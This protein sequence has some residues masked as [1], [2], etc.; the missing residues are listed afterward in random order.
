MVGL[1]VCGVV[2]LYLP[3]SKDFCRI[4][5]RDLAYRYHIVYSWKVV[6][7]NTHHKSSIGG[8]DRQTEFS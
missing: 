4:R 7:L 1:V 3:I 8:E 5:P 2:Y 6:H